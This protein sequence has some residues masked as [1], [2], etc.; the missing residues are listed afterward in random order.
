MRVITVYKFFQVSPQDEIWDSEVWQPYKPWDTLHMKMDFVTHYHIT[1]STKPLLLNRFWNSISS[2]LS[3]HADTAPHHIVKVHSEMCQVALHNLYNNIFHSSAHYI[4]YNYG[5]R[6]PGKV[7]EVPTAYFKVWFQHVWSDRV[8]KE[9]LRVISF[10]TQIS[11]ET[12][13][14]PAWYLVHIVCDMSMW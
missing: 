5:H 9:N 3:Q 11:T 6:R 14:A 13:W 8:E 2:S 10:Y 4:C 12:L 7:M 1:Y